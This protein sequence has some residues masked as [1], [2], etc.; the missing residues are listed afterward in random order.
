[1][2]A[3]LCTRHGKVES[4]FRAGGEVAEKTAEVLGSVGSL[5]WRPPRWLGIFPDQY[6][7]VRAVNVGHLSWRPPTWLG[8]FASPF[9]AA[10]NVVGVF[11][12]VFAPTTWLGDF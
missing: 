8:D 4:T 3:T 11:A 7:T 2:R 6:P 12:G 1:M 9:M 5:S 10:A